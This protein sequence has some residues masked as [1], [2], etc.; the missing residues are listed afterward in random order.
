MAVVTV[1]K[2]RYT[3]DKLYQWDLNQTLQIY[4]LSLAS[5]PEIHFTN[6]AMDGAIV[7]QA[8]MDGAGV[9]TAD[10]PNSLL[11]KP[12]KITAYVCVYAGDTFETLY[13][14]NIPVKARQ[15]PNDYT[16]EDNDEEIY[17]FNAL[18]N[19]TNNL[20]SSN[21][22]FKE[23]IT[24]AFDSFKSGVENVIEGVKSHVNRVDNPHNVTAEQIG[25]LPVEG[26]SIT[27]DTLG[28]NNNHAQ[29]V[30]DSDDVQIKHLANNEDITCHTAIRIS[31]NES[32]MNSLKLLKRVDDVENEYH[33]H[34][35]HNKPT[36]SYVGNGDSTAREI[37]TGG[38]GSMVVITSEN[39][40]AWI[41]DTNA[42]FLY[43]NNNTGK[44]EISSSD[45]IFKNKSVIHLTTTHTAL[46]ANNITYTYYVL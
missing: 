46:N 12:N 3:V 17:S 39:G 36:A 23:T 37:M 20:I 44:Y 21:T 35:D 45:C 7:R 14:I 22:T 6:T 41:N 10:I 19:K 11:Q 4:G 15:K 13:T 25:A 33:L 28:I 18:T 2:N 40:M 34:G 24:N 5:I 9:I 30:A 43:N 29:A 26:G 8:Q 31:D 38:Y 32:L 16:I 42:Y 1:E 27:G